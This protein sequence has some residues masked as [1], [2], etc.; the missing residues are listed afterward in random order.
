M[1]DKLEIAGREVKI[2]KFLSLV[3][4]HKPETIN[5]ELD[6]NGWVSISELLD[7][8]SR[9]KFSIT[10]L[11]LQSVVANNKKQRFAISEDGTRIRAN[12]GHSIAIDLDYI[13]TM[14]PEVLYHGTAERFLSSILSIG[15]VKQNRHHVHMSSD[16]TTA[17]Q[18]GSRHGKPAILQI[19]ALQMHKESYQF[20]ESENGVWLTDRV[21]VIYL[22]VLD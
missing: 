16:R 21:P 14:P 17:H 12:Q 11:E 13:P 15:L 20:F 3:L 2:S 19:M 18:V 5:L 6:R 4:R 22:K 7:A 8:C 9:N 1:P 10:L